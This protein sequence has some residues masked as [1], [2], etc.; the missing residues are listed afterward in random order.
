MAKKVSMVS[1]VAREEALVPE[2]KT[3]LAA[4]CDLKADIRGQIVLH[5]GTSAIIPTG[6]R[7][8]LPAGYE[9]QIRGRSGLN[10][11]NGIVVPVSTID[12]DYRGEVRVK[13]YNLGGEVYCINPLDRIA[14]LVISKVERVE[15]AKVES[16]DE[17]ERGEGGFGHTGK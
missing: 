9:G 4:G 7:L 10:F 13:V 8:A 11:K 6:I 12:A 3:A 14:Q 2:Y 1:I 17:T 15:F 5:P 16:L